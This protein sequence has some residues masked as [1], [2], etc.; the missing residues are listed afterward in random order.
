[1]SFLLFYGFLR[2]LTSFY[3]VFNRT[4]VG[5]NNEKIV[6]LDIPCNCNRSVKQIFL[7]ENKIIKWSDHAFLFQEAII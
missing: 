2:F 6:D 1:M 7:Q 3:T 4:D 5:F